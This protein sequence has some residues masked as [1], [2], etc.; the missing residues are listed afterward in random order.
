MVN[1]IFL[2]KIII[3]I[4]ITLLIGINIFPSTI[5]IS[6]EKYPINPSF[7]STFYVGGNGPNNYTSIQAAIDDAFDGDTVFVFDDSSPYYENI[8]IDKSINLLGENKESTIIDGSSINDV[9]YISADF[10]IV[11]SFTIQNCGDSIWDS[12][13][14]LHSHI[15][16]ISD[17]IVQTNGNNGISVFMSNANIIIN[18]Q[19]ISNENYGIFIQASIDNT[20][21]NN[22]LEYNNHTGVYLDISD[23]NIISDCA[24][25][26]NDAGIT[27]ISSNDNTISSNVIFSNNGDGISIENSNYNEIFSNIIDSNDDNGLQLYHS[28]NIDIYENDILNN[29]EYGIF[30]QYISNNNNINDNVIYNN[31]LSGIALESNSNNN[32]IRSNELSYNDKGVGILECRYNIIEENEIFNNQCALS[33][34]YFETDNVII[35][36]II[37]NNIDGIIINQNSNNN[38]IYHNFFINNDQHAYDESS[39]N[40]DDG[41]PS[42]G[43]Y[44]DDYNGTDRDG[45]GIGD[46]PYD[47][48][49]GDNQD[50]YPLGFFTTPHE[51]T[52]TGTTSGRFGIDYDYTFISTD[53]NG[54]DLYYYIEWGDNSVEEWI[55][56]YSSGE[57]VDVSH[58]WSSRGTYIIRAKVKDV[59]GAESTWGS[60]EVSMPFYQ[61]SIV[62]LF[63]RFVEKIIELFP[64]LQKIFV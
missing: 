51:P 15:N 5:G 30:L 55:G 56:P 37:E 34:P 57:H 27:L 45:D 17:T 46:I 6:G 18:N 7:A 64:I 38:F 48:E 58:N 21:I 44:W 24:L 10:V 61:I 4:V 29:H 12:G 41:Y 19:I 23:G 62:S 52:I 11:Q 43:N 40:W 1:K 33:M 54:D 8:V 36:N 53:P 31:I 35:D 50:L 14:E 22:Q 3:C 28:D 16:E 2:K 63:Q 20:I 26:E 13:I 59:H 47:I 49:G 25:I 42:G 32:L 60:L 39:N 9:V